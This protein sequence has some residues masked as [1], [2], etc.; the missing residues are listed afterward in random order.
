[1][2]CRIF[3]FPSYYKKIPLDPREA[4]KLTIVTFSA[5]WCEAQ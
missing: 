1:M 5:I 4:T 2:A 3:D